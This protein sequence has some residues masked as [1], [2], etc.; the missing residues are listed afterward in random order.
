MADNLLL[1]QIVKFYKIGDNLYFETN[2]KIRQMKFLKIFS[3]SALMHFTIYL[4]HYC[5]LANSHEQ[6]QICKYLKIVYKK[7]NLCI[8]RP[9]A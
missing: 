5:W 6:E 7:Q 1:M 8:S 2:L 4:I 9:I 3:L